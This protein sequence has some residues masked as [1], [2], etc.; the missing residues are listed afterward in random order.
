MQDLFSNYYQ[1]YLT[2]SYDSVD[3]IVLNAHYIRGCIPGGF[4]LM[5]R[6]LYGSDKNLDNAHLMRLAQRTGRRIRAFAKENDIP[7]ID[8]R[9]NERKDTIAADYIP[10]DPTYTG[11]FL[12]LVGRAPA[13]VWDVQHTK[14][15]RIKNIGRKKHLSFVNHYHFH[16]MDAEWGHI[17]IR[18]CGHLPF[19]TQ[20]ILN[21]HEYV[22][23]HAK[24]LGIKFTKEDNCF[25]EIADAAHLCKVADTLSQNGAAGR[26]SQVCE[27]W[28]YTACLCFA[29]TSDEQKRCGFSY[30]YYVYQ[31]EY[32]RNLLFKRG[33]DPDQVFHGIVDRTRRTVAVKTL[34]TIFGAKHRPHQN[35]K[36]KARVEVVI[37]TPTYDLTVFKVHFDR[38]TAKLYTKGEHVLRV[39]IIIH[40]ARAMKIGISLPK[41]AEIIQRLQSI[42][43][44]F[45]E[46]IHWMDTAAIADSTMDELPASSQVG[47]SR[48]GGID[49]NKYRTRLVMQAVIELCTQPYGFTSSQLAEK[50]QDRLCNIEYTP[51]KAAYDLKKLRAKELVSKKNNARK[52]VATQNGLRTMV[53]LLTLREKVI[54]PILTG[55][56]KTT[57]RRKPINQSPLDIAYRNIQDNM[58]MLFSVVGI[59]V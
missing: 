39:E 24:K 46:T 41:F 33:S 6:D 2:T 21:G 59:A 28:L 34:K 40:N 30:Q 15:G 43:E 56:C 20:V 55:S 27:R 22:A 14:D 9:T 45:L 47:A 18:M 11:L 35:R 57:R 23:S 7:V 44:R 31:A 29:L 49:I 54:K 52:Y 48:V 25:T 50:V 3:R 32:S 10:D 37:E 26:L 38:L 36:K 17:I 16:I 4:R 58:I 51:K 53:A 42:L 1:D 8:T 19:S 5:W 13:S 12:I